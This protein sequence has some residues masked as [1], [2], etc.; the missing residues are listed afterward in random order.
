[1]TPRNNSFCVAIYSLISE[2]TT[3]CSGSSHTELAR[4]AHGHCTRD[5][6]E[7]SHFALPYTPLSFNQS[8]GF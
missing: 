6:E 2:I 1:M 7:L 4:M 8:P 5:I 3:S